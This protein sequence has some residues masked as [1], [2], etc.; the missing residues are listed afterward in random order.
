MKG[1]DFIFGFVVGA[2]VG[3]E[4]NAFLIEAKRARLTEGAIYPN[5]QLVEVCHK[6]ACE[7]N[8]SGHRKNHSF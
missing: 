6:P 1:I 3:I 4:I 7:T 2:I 8:I 5:G